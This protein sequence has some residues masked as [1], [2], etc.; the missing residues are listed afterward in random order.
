MVVR[1][2][3]RIQELNKIR[4][5]GLFTSFTTGL[6]SLD[7][8]YRIVKGYPLFVA[9]APHH[10]KSEFTLELAIS[11]A[12]RHGFKWCCY[13]GESG[14]TEVSIMEIATK[15]IGKPYFGQSRMSDSE[16]EQA[17][18]FVS[19]HFYFIELEEITV[20]SF[21]K[22]V[23]E[24][25]VELEIK[26]DG[27]I[28]DP[29]NDVSNETGAHGGTHIWLENDLKH[30]RQQSQEHK[31]VDIVVNHIADVSPVQNPDTKE[32]YTPPARPNQWAGGQ[33]WHR[34]AMTMLL[35]YR[36][37]PSM[38]DENGSPY[39]EDT[40]IIYNQKAKP[41]GSGRLG[42][43]VIRWDWMRNR[44]YEQVSGFDKYMLEYSKTQASPQMPKN[45]AFETKANITIEPR[46]D[47]EDPF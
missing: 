16:R 31:R 24:A 22:A 45:T 33:V 29:F 42:S 36:V 26:F 5:S 34:R 1:I 12:I 18:Y 27:T 7:S 6:E 19:T 38:R 15:Y 20:K 30:I 28:L 25:Q 13:L 4:E 11:S 41:K 21:Y 37:H 3:D 40:T 47:E 46:R 39:P 10:G 35:V 14:K 32:W 2:E 43:A 44:Y 17:H 9:G 23:L 8:I